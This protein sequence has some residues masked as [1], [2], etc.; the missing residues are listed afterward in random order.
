MAVEPVGARLLRPILEPVL[1]K[2]IG[3]GLAGLAAHV[4]G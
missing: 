3:D 1:R 2:A 4:R